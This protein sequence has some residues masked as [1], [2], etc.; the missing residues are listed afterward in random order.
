MFKR[1]RKFW[2]LHEK[3]LLLVVS[4]VSVF[5]L[6]FLAHKV[7]SLNSLTADIKIE[8]SQANSSIFKETQTVDSGQVSGASQ[9]AV[10]ECKPGQIKGNISSSSQIYHV[11]GGSSYNKLQAEACFDTEAEAQ[12]AGFRKALR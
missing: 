10:G 2:Q 5:V 11:P 1:S 12:A 8:Q 3:E 9:T 6:G 4:F 7:S